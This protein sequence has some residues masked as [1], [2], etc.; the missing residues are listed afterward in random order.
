MIREAAFRLKGGD[1][2]LDITPRQRGASRTVATSL[3]LGSNAAARPSDKRLRRC[4]VSAVPLTGRLVSRR[5]SQ[6]D[7]AAS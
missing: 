4:P 2:R 5:R 7:A 6:T 1:G 3:D